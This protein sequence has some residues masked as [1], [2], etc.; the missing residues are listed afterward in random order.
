MIHKI[1]V[2]DMDL[3]WK[4]SPILFQTSCS[5]GGRFD[6]VALHQ[7]FWTLEARAGVT[8]Y[9]MEN[10]VFPNAQDETSLPK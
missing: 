5:A 10:L 3:S 4:G 1:R 6:L 9:A 7:H 2:P 8:A